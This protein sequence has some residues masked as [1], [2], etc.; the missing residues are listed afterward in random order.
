MKGERSR[1]STLDW[2]FL[3]QLLW[4]VPTL[5]GQ[6][7]AEDIARA[8]GQWTETDCVYRHDL[9]SYRMRLMTRQNRQDVVREATDI[10]ICMYA[11]LTHG[12]EGYGENGRNIHRH[13]LDRLYASM[14]KQKRN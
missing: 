4:C 10:Y 3:L 13:S 5:P 2:A 9:H 8:K 6:A 12:H 14:I 7:R 1:K 11:R